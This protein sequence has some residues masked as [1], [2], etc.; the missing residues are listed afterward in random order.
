MR[1]LGNRNNNFLGHGPTL[2]FC[3]GITRECFAAGGENITIEP[4]QPKRFRISAYVLTLKMTVQVL[5]NDREQGIA[6]LLEKISELKKTVPV[7]LALFEKLEK[8]VAQKFS[9][10]FRGFEY[11]NSLNREWRSA[12]NDELKRMI[13]TVE[14]GES[15]N[16]QRT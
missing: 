11:L 4:S 15:A 12:S 8:L 3:G 5:S 2:A 9:S 13:E 1:R 7:R 10:R 16:F 6:E 14:A